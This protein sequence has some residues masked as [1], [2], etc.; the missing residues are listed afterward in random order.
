[1]TTYMYMYICYLQIKDQN[2]S[3]ST[4]MYDQLHRE[5]KFIL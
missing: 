1:M 4:Y 2:R 3:K 5:L